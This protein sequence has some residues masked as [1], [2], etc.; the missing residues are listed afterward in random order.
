MIDAGQVEKIVTE[1]ERIH[2]AAKKLTADLANAAKLAARINNTY[3]GGQPSD[4]V[5]TANQLT[6][7]IL[8]VLWTFRGLLDNLKHP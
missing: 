8:P 6:N 4:L 1:Y 7:D 2:N 5:G 3:G